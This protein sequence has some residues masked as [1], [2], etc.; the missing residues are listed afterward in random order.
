MSVRRKPV[1]ARVIPD[2]SLYMSRKKGIHMYD[3][4]LPVT[5]NSDELAD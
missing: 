5:G 2:I 1:W 3:E 4:E